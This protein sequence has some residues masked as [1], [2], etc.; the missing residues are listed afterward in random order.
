MQ[1]MIGNNIIVEVEVFVHYR[2]G[3]TEKDIERLIILYLK[4]TL[5]IDFTLR[6]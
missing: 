1:V 4:D 3:I 2:K 6:M 5:S